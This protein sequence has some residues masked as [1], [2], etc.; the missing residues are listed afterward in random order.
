[1]R[2]DQSINESASQRLE[3]ATSAVFVSGRERGILKSSE[4]APR[5]AMGS[6]G[7]IRP[8]SRTNQAEGKVFR[9]SFQHAHIAIVSEGQDTSMAAATLIGAAKSTK[10]GVPH[11]IARSHGHKDPAATGCLVFKDNRLS[12]RTQ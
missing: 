4:P 9:P 1:V 10:Q 12:D 5:L 6:H 2:Y 8:I 7:I 3:C 11:C